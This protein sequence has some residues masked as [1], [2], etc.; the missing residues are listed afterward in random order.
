MQ[1]GL[2]CFAVIGRAHELETV[3]RF[4]AALAD[5]AALL[6]LEG[7][8]GIGKTTLMRAAVEAARAQEAHVLAC[9]AG[10]SETRL[11]Y[12][13]LADLLRSVDPDV[14][15]ALPE[16]QREALDG[17]LLRARPGDGEV[18]RRAVGT[19]ALSV[20]EALAREAP[21]VLAIDDVQ[22]LDRP[23]AHM[24]EFCARR[25]P[26][27]VGLLA[28]RRVDEESAWT[29]GLLRVHSTEQ[30]EICALTP[31]S[32]PELQRLL[33]ERL[34]QPLDRRTLLRVHEAS[35][36]NPFYAIE[37]A[38]A[39]PADAPPAPALPLPASLDDVVA[40]RI[41]G[42]DGEVEDALLAVAVLAR[43]TIDLLERV[44]GPEA[45]ARL[46]DAE[47]LGMLELDAGRLRFTH[48]LLAAGVYA[49]ATSGRRR[50]MHRRLAEE[51]G[52]VEERARHLAFAGMPNAIPALEDASEHLRA[53]GAPDAA[54]ELL[55]LALTV[56]GEETLRHRAA[57]RHFDAGESRRARTLVEETIAA[58]PPG[59]ARAASL[60]LLGEIHY[61]GDSFT[62]AYAA[63]EQAAAEAGD[64]DRLHVMIDLRRSFTGWNIAGPDAGVEP[65]HAALERARRLGEPG[66]LGQALGS[67]VLVDF[68]VGH[69]LDDARL[70]DALELE[71]FDAPPGSE[72]TPSVLA[73]FL[74]LWCGRLDEARVTLRSATTG[75]AHRGEEHA[76]AW[77]EYIRVWLEFWYGDLAAAEAAA[78]G[79]VERLLLLETETGR[80]L[81]L[82]TQALVDALAGRV[83]DARRNAADAL[84]VYEQA[85]WNGGMGWA[86]NALGFAAL[87]VRDDEGAAAALAPLA[88]RV[89]EAGMPEP[90]AGGWLFVGD[91]AE[92]LT[93]VGR[94]E[95][96]EAIAAL[97]EQRG[98]ALDRAWAI[99][100]GARCRGLL[101]AASGDVAGAEAAL[102][103][104]LEAHERL[105]M[106]LERGRSLLVLGRI[107]RRQRKRLAA[108]AALDEALAVFRAARSPRW[109]EQTE[110]EIAAIGLRRG[111]ADELTAS[112][113]RVAR[114]AASGLTNKEVA[115]T[116][117][118]SQKTV[119]AHL[120]RVYRKLGIHS[121]AELGA[122]LAT[123]P[124][125][126]Q[127][128]VRA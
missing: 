62:A 56:G 20:L 19:A 14:L 72:F 35:G 37:L 46:D 99:A 89:V 52:D 44:L 50:A 92:A 105:P 12:A 49:R 32:V 25:L 11:A 8:A 96:A 117:I 16:P 104:A 43:P 103:R 18:D 75:H 65:A 15:A 119:E 38:R 23:S 9:T 112:E 87:S 34:P 1:D 84:A 122:R 33:R 28:S 76:L 121:R 54:A 108:K 77:M 81:A 26:D 70:T 30:I 59:P 51:V 13:A 113:E 47:A 94:T 68:C 116:L 110:A 31:L 85:T 21:V 124:G 79:G 111:A 91:A 55:E 39:I 64:D 60:L 82:T 126:P 27:R 67:S 42:L 2:G 41:A 36:G 61:K 4:L 98:A 97:L 53:R 7:E 71:A 3:D 128:P 125:D 29:A 115:A 69:G 80:A 22:W 102:E 58:L 114:L 74:Y 57:E 127:T 109:V 45:A 66:L 90:T 93:A 100:V 24:V 40:A 6:M 17:A 95:E 63:L 10:A 83:E 78:D 48:P 73:T 107:R 5:R 101:L 120:A 106:P 86:L 118:V 123:P 88:A